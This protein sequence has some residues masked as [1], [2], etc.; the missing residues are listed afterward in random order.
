ML[1][2]TTVAGVIP[3]TRPTLFELSDRYAMNRAEL[4]VFHRIYGLDR[5]PVWHASIGD[6]VEQAVVKLLKQPGVDAGRVRWL[7]HAHTGSQQNVVGSAILA[8]ICAR[9]GLDRAQPFG[10][11]TNNC[12]SVIS[13]MQVVDR[14]LRRG[15]PGDQ[16]IVVSADV[17]F[18]PILQLIPNSS[19][20][21][22]AAVAC[23]FSRD[24]HGHRVLSSRID[25]YG[26]HASCQ[27]QDEAAS[28]EFEAEYPGRV[29]LTMRRALAESG[30]TWDDIKL[31]LPHNVNLFSWKRVAAHAGIPI[32]LI[33]L[34]QVPETAHCF[35]ADI[36]LNFD[37]AQ[38]Q[39]RF[40][41]GDKLMLVTVGLGALFAA[42]VIEYGG[43][44]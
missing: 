44:G 9:L 43:L 20:T 30:L 13:A 40:A 25:V 4:M 33:Y 5:V 8:G 19:V 31:V 22:D 26:Q 35:G 21:G 7:V 3:P 28:A 42:A 14:L 39:G 24:G 37:A 1:R 2:M 12:A 10:V 32:G 34:E 15:Q 38:R 18:T 23:L 27:W 36:F 29:A 16:A 11:T 41:A 6:L 17:A